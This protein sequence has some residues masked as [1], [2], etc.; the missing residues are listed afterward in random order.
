L[1]E[2]LPEAEKKQRC[3]WLKD[4][5]GVPWQI[6]PSVLG[7]MLHHSEIKKGHAGNAPS[8]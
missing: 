3:G 6:V 5:Y 2:K 1:W 7:E 8:G 4:K